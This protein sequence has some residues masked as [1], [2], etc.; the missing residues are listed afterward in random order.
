VAVEGVALDGAAVFGEAALAA[1]VERG[2]YE[3]GGDVLELVVPL[4]AVAG[5]AVEL[6]E[7]G[8]R[9]FGFLGVRS[10]NGC[11]TCRRFR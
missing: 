6:E 9:P 10:C 4:S 1:A 7:R 2:Y 3:A 11:A 8:W 5:V